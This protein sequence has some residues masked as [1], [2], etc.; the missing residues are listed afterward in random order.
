MIA[1]NAELCR[2][3]RHEY[4]GERGERRGGGMQV[5]GEH[6]RGEGRAVNSF[7]LPS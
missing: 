5:D 7:K 2:A 6:G 4:G 1:N 3:D